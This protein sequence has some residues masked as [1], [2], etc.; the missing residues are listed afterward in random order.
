MR[1]TLLVFALIVLVSCGD[2]RLQPVQRAVV[3]LLNNPDVG[4]DVTNHRLLTI[5]IADS[6][7]RGVPPDEKR[8]KALEIATAGYLAY[9][10]RSALE[11]VD[12]VVPDSFSFQS[13][14]L[15]ATTSAHTDWR[16]PTPPAGALYFVAIGDEAESLI[17]GLAAGM[18]QR[19][20]MTVNVLPHLSFDRTTFDR[21]RNQF[22]A[23]E[24]LRAVRERYGSI[25]QQPN[26]VIAVTSYDMYMREQNWAFTFSL[27]DQGDHSAVVSYARMDPAFFGNARDE[28]LLQ[29]RLRKMVTKNIGVLCYGLPLSGDPRS[30]LY[31]NIGGTDELDVITEDFAPLGHLE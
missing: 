13:S 23:D 21:N 9:A 6:L 16:P 27:R 18:R 26:S 15:V 8:R 3:R 2:L 24:L 28:K 25:V 30:V 11:R 31:G 4:V 29:S 14:Q 5:R 1:R 12:V 17:E 7:F 19:F 10:N 22:V 20:S